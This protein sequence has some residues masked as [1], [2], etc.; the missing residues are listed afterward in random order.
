MLGIPIYGCNVSVVE[1][2][3]PPRVRHADNTSHDH[4]YLAVVTYNCTGGMRFEDGHTSKSIKCIDPGVWN[5]SVN[6][7]AST[8]NTSILS[9][10]LSVTATHNVPLRFHQMH[11]VF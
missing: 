1:C 7:C 11:R 8:C 10:L 9:L 4:V 2:P 6:D 3:E 5:D